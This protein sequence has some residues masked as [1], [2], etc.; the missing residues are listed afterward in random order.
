MAA[1]VLGGGVNDEVRAER[2]GLLQVRRG[3]R[4]VYRED[5]PMSVRQFSDGGDIHDVQ[6]GVGWCF[7]PDQLGT[8]ADEC[9]ES[10]RREVL[11]VVC[12]DAPLGRK[13]RSSRR[14]VPP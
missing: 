3:K 6:E 8:R 1:Q 4:A 14:Y 12:D 2:Q 9:G 10:F 11:G 7:D 13:T 5:G